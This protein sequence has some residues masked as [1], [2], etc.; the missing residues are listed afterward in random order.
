MPGAEVTLHGRGFGQA[1]GHVVVTGRRVPPRSWSDEQITF[2]VP[3]DA[4]TGFVSVRPADREASGWVSLAIERRLPAGQ[5]APHGLRLE[6]TGLPGAAFLVETDGSHV[7]GITGFETLCTYQLRGTQ[8]HAFRSRVYLNQRVA[9]LRVRD[10]FLFCVGDHGLLVYR[11][12]DLQAGEA[13]VTAAVAGASFMGVDVRPDAAAE[14]EGLLVALCEHAPRPGADELRVVFYQ[15]VGEELVPLGEFTRTAGPEERQFAVALDPL[16]RKAYVSGWGT[17]NGADKYLLELRLDDPGRPFLGHREETGRSLAGDMEAIGNRLW[18]GVTTTVPGN[19]LFRVYLLGPGERHLVPGPIITGRPALGRVA[20]VDVLDRKVTVG[21]AWYGNRPDIFLLST[22]GP[23]TT[24][25]ASAD[26]LDWAFDVAGLASATEAGAGKVIVADEWGGFLTLDYE[27]TR[28]ARLSHETDYQR[29]EAAAMTEGLHLA[30][31]RVYV[32]GR[33]AGPWS[34]EA[35]ALADESRWRRVKFDWTDPD[36]Q[37][38]PVSAVC[39][40]DDPH[41]GTLIAALGHEKAM[42]WGNQIIGLLYRETAGGIEL[43]AQAEPFNP[44]GQWS[45]GVSAVWPEP[46]LVYM[47]TGSDGFRAWVVDPTAS[48]ISLHADCA[49][50]GFATDVFSTTLA[51]RCLRPLAMGETRRM[52]VGATPGL[53]VGKPTLHVFTLDY[54]LGVP[55]RVRPDAPIRVE[56]EAALECMKWKTIQNLDVQPSGLVAAATG[57]GLAVLHLS[58]VSALNA[59][60]DLTAWNLIR[61]PPEAY[62]PWWAPD[63]GPDVADVSFADDNTLYV[64]K[65]PEGLWRLTIELDRANRTHRCMATGFYPGVNCGMDYRRQ[66]HGWAAPDIPTLHHP[67][68]V[69]ARGETAFVT[70]WSGKVQ[71]LA[72]DAGSGVRVLGFATEGANVSI[73]FASPFSNRR[74]ELETAAGLRGV[75]WAAC[76]GAIIRS[77]GRDRYEAVCAAPGDPSG[78]YRIRVR[79]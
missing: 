19:E 75:R 78:F 42:A 25:S 73:R 69:V 49:T 60:T 57:T 9:D 44:P 6:D 38:H 76:S 36:P 72:P 55:S 64:V 2:V 59:M 21:C 7:Y 45:S 13:T 43:V 53:L 41:D 67:Y 37:P 58:W 77:L 46:D 47:A 56:H 29:V 24:P 10:G 62:A 31:D 63:W 66:L 8:P 33:G 32:A 52:I 14:R 68:G 51:A 23:D 16:T 17:L 40:R 39:T 1:S 15:F 74:H 4:A 27:T 22:F 65:A 3:E 50:S 5:I 34:A 70:G 61:V 54:P 20:R 71:R 11:C 48:T 26:S 28:E 12:A 35:G 18:T 79:P 30:G